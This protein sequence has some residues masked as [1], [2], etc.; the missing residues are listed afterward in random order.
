[1][2]YSR[3]ATLGL[4]QRSLK[5]LQIMS[6]TKKLKTTHDR[7]GAAKPNVTNALDL[8]R[9][10]NTHHKPRGQNRPQ[11]ARPGVTDLGDGAEVFYASKFL[12]KTV[13]D[14]GFQ[15]LL[16]EIEWEHREITVM[17]RKVLQ[18]RLIAYQADDPSLTY[19]YS[20]MT[21][22]PSGWHPTVLNIKVGDAIL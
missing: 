2:L 14:D 19:T 3:Y 16:L 18:P 9:G 22:V 8:L 13:A 10:Y 17:G 7:C 21:L 5:L 20:R 15:R 6:A 1:M 4:P 12:A 11:Q